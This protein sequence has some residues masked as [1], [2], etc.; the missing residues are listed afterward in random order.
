M[1]LDRL[2]HRKVVQL[3][4]EQDSADRV[5]VARGPV[6]DEQPVVS[7]DVGGTEVSLPAAPVERV[8]LP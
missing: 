2:L 4:C 5:E 1:P 6:V 7:I 8:V 3:V